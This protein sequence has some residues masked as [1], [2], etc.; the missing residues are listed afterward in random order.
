MANP[1]VDEQVLRVIVNRASPRPADFRLRKGEN[2]LSLFLGSM[3]PTTRII[4]A[5]QAAGKKGELTV[6]VIPVSLLYDL[7]LTIVATPGGTAD[8]EVNAIHVEARFPFLSRLI[9][10]LKGRTVH[11]EFNER[12]SPRIAQAATILG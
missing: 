3:V 4:D 7:G 6:A 9:L 8:R 10:R 12:V 1:N 11:D 2:G 5:V